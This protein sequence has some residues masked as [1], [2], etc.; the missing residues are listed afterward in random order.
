MKNIKINEHMEKPILPQ[1]P[2]IFDKKKYPQPPT[3]EGRNYL[4]EPIYLPN[5]DYV[6]DYEQYR[7]DL[8]KYKVDIEIYKQLK[9]IKLIKVSKPDFIIRKFLITKK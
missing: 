3:K 7:K 6:R 5:K 9:Y 4:N 2:N 1:E 8:E